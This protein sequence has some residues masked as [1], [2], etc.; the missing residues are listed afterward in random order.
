[1]SLSVEGMTLSHCS[2]SFPL[3]IVLRVLQS[4]PTRIEVRVES[5]FSVLHDLSSAVRDHSP[6][7]LVISGAE[8]F[9]SSEGS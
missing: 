4:N 1:V 6:Y 9:S 2:V 5:S 3:R 8:G 7:I